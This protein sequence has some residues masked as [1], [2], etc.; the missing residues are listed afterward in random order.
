MYKINDKFTHTIN[1]EEY[2]I[3]G[4]WDGRSPGLHHTFLMKSNGKGHTYAGKVTKV[5]HVQ[6]ITE[7]EFLDISET[8]IQLNF[9]VTPNEVYTF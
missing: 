8:D 5:N 1:M 7:D 6:N 3:K 4:A 9:C 2:T